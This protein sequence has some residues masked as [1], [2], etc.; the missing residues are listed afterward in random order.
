MSEKP[1]NSL[2]S[3]ISGTANQSVIPSS[4][5]LESL[6]LLQFFNSASN[7]DPD[8]KALVDEETKYLK[9]AIRMVNTDPLIASKFGTDLTSAM[10]L[11]G[12]LK[13]IYAEKQ[14]KDHLLNYI[15]AG[16]VETS[17]A[18]KKMGELRRTASAIRTSD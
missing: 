8:I 10:N 17:E 16:A 2:Y 15:N 12:L 11:S 13:E 3:V 9:S 1:S 4:S 18:Q 6:K 7:L 5:A 14:A